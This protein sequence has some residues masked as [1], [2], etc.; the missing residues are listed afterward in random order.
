MWL[1]ERYKEL[2]QPADADDFQEIIKVLKACI[3]VKRQKMGDIDY[4]KFPEYIFTTYEQLDKDIALIHKALE[5]PEGLVDGK[6]ID[7]RL[8]KDPPY[9]FAAGRDYF[10]NSIN[11]AEL[12]TRLDN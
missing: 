8:F 11:L 5:D 6:R 4:T 3:L 9:G 10:A 12:Y 1:A 7:L 2:D